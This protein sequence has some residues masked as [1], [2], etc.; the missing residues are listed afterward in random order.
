MQAPTSETARKALK[1][2]QPYKDHPKRILR[3]LQALKA[4]QE[5]ISSNIINSEKNNQRSATG[6]RITGT[7]PV[8]FP[9]F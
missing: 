4:R 1:D 5:Y 8:K 2:L 3:N 7:Y 9:A 6:K